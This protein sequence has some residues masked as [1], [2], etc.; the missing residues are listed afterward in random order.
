MSFPQVRRVVISQTIIQR[1][2]ARYFPRV[3][4]VKPKLLFTHTRAR[5]IGHL[6]LIDLAQEETG[7]AESDIGAIHSQV[8]EGLARFSG[9]EGISPGRSVASGDAGG[10]PP[11]P[12]RVNRP[13]SLFPAYPPPDSP[14]DARRLRPDRER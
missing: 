11:A 7:V 9:G 14:S 10:G 8:L 4:S 13:T 6:Y 2:S 1:E 12:A 5:R 3:L